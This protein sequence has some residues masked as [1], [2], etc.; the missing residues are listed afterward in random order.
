MRENAHIHSGKVNISVKNP[1]AIYIFQVRAI[2][3]FCALMNLSA[4]PVHTIIARSL[5]GY[6]SRV[7]TNNKNDNLDEHE[8]KR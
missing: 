8:I 3:Y 5:P 6:L 1:N 4:L 7:N 2:A